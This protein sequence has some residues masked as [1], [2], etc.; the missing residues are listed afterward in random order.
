MSDLLS[1]LFA[2]IIMQLVEEQINWVWI[3]ESVMLYL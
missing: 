2:D 3:S 1:V